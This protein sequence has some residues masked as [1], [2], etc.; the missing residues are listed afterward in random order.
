MTTKTE[1][2]PDESPFV[3]GPGH[4]KSMPLKT[5]SNTFWDYISNGGKNS[6][7]SLFGYP[8]IGAYLQ[9]KYQQGIRIDCTGKFDQKGKFSYLSW[10]WAENEAM[11][12]HPLIWIED[13]KYQQP[14]GTFLPYVQTDTGFFVG[15]KIQLHPLAPI[16]QITYAVIKQDKGSAITVNM[17]PTALDI[18]NALQRAK[19]K[20]IAQKT[21]IAFH[22]FAGEDLPDTFAGGIAA[23]NEDILEV[24]S[25]LDHPACDKSI[26]GTKSTI[27]DLYTKK[28]EDSGWSKRD[29]EATIKLLTTQRNAW[30]AQEAVTA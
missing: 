11:K 6:I 18:T 20:L 10:A 27:R 8:D 30:E 29:V 21:G 2:V 3:H 25:L 28:L 12:L 7:D 26:P 15:A 4:G 23:E 17:K 9:D 14:D 13:E 24:K 5:T 1:P 19:T 22:I 16:H